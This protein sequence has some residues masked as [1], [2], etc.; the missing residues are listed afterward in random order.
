MP[1]VRTLAGISCFNKKED[2]VSS[3][4]SSLV[5]LSYIIILFAY[6]R[7]PVQEMDISY[8]LLASKG[9]IFWIIGLAIFSPSFYK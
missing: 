7:F 4:T 3:N 2:T 6:A 1:F 5:S 9:K 8:G